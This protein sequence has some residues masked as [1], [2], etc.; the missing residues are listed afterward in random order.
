MNRLSYLRHSPAFLSS[1]LSSPKARFILYHNLNP[2]ASPP[3]TDGSI[4]LKSVTFDEVREFLG[5]ESGQIF[6]WCDDKDEK[7]TTVVVEGSIEEKLASIERP[8]VVFLGVDER[9]A[10]ASAKSLP[11]SKPTPDSTLE[12]HSPYGIPY[13]ALDVS[14][15]DG[16]RNKELGVEGATFVDMR[17][18]MAAIPNEEAALAGEG[19][20]LI[21]WNKRN[22]VR[23]FPFIFR[24]ISHAWYGVVLSCLCEKDEIA[25]GWVEEGLCQS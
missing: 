7:N 4:K 12:A 15:L 18:G 5:A 21:D 13:F 6:K 11:L 17:A 20:A 23:P 24:T 9:S 2:L 10:P 19:R 25:L 22:V 8:A 14:E 3:A 16:L 1:A